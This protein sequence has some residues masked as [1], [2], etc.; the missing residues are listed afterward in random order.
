MARPERKNVDY[1]PFICKEGRAM[2]YIEEKYGNDG[3]AT[4]VK[5]L[6]QLAVTDYHFLNL[7]EEVD[8]MFLS[9]KCKI[10][11]ETLNCIINDLVKLGEFDKSLWE[12]CS[13]LWSEKFIENIKDAYTKRNG[14][15]LTLSSLR[16]HLSSLGILKPSKG[17]K[18]GVSNTHI[19]LKDIKEDN[20]REDNKREREEKFRLSAHTLS[21]QK[22][23][24]NSF[25]DYWTESKPN[26]KKMKF[27]MEKTFDITRRLN[28][29]IKNEQEWKPKKQ[30]T[31]SKLNP[32]TK[33]FEDE[34]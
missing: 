33:I 29:W 23:I 17:K 1:F 4:W 27:E 3:F 21:D 11:N 8:M 16:S 28:T 2:F 7:S 14:N 31:V 6:R 5:L 25:C 26:G 12:E 15:I 24:V 10:S 9:A 18:S 30:E 20:I 32:T 19:I 22:S 13:V 34:L